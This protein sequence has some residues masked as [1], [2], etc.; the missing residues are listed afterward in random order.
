LSR[1]NCFHADDLAVLRAIANL[2]A[3]AIDGDAL[4]RST[5]TRG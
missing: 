4:R 5:P 3:V 2:A 1:T